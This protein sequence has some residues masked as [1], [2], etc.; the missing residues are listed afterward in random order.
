VSSFP[1]FRTVEKHDS[2]RRAQ[3]TRQRPGAPRGKYFGQIPSWLIKRKLVHIIFVVRKS[4]RPIDP[5]MHAACAYSAKTVS[6]PNS[7]ISLQ[8]GA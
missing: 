3:H 6:D 4:G 8:A 2:P 5:T 7:F 1:F